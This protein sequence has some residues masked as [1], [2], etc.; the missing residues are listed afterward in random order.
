[1]ELWKHRNSIVFEGKTPDVRA[2]PR[3]I[4]A[5]CAV[6]MKAGIIHSDLEPWMAGIGV[7]ADRE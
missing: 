6:W 2:L 5:E 7:W 3:R 4:A 1:M